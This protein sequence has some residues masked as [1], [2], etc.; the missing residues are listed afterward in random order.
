[1]KAALGPMKLQFDSSLFATI[2]RKHGTKQHG[3]VNGCHATEVA[4]L[5]PAGS[6][7][8]DQYCARVFLSGCGKEPAVADVIGDFVM[9][10]E[11]T[12]STCHAA[13]P[14]IKIHD[15]R[16]RDARQQR[17]RRSEQSH[18]LLVAMPMKK[19]FFRAPF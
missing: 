19:D 13:A 9:L 14:G 16:I 6:T 18:C 4:N 1:M 17:L 12:K 8:R 15:R 11:V 3:R 2:F 10:A 7:W 5:M